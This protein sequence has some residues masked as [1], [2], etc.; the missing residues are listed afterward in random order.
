MSFSTLFPRANPLALDLLA[1]LLN[2]DPAKRITC[3]QALN[4]PY[5]AVWHDPADE[6]DCPSVSCTVIQNLAVL[7]RGLQ[8][9]DFGFEEE[10][11]IEGMK[12]LI[13]EE[14]QSFRSEVRQQARTGGQMQRQPR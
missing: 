12:R 7:T 2:F 3:E 6:P 9:F 11:G 13:V 1:Q 4:H 14:V 10:D 5:L 8:S